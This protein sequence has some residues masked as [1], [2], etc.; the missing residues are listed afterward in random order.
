MIVF[1]GPAGAGKSVQGQFL[2]VRHGWEWLST[3]QILRAST[4]PNVQEQIHSGV[5]VSPETVDRVLV[6]A[7]EGAQAAKEII[8][9]GYPRK[10]QQAE[11][12]IE[13]KDRHHRTIELAIVLEVPLEELQKRLLKRG[14]KDDSTDAIQERLAIYTKEIDSILAFLSQ[15][16]VKI[17]RVNGVGSMGEVHDRIEKELE[18][19]GAIPVDAL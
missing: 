9:D 7:L 6:E 10:Q 11:W 19:S 17:I 3:G 14:R 16:N 1:F 12:I 8:L 2:A 4:D 5:L 15:H 18:V 13:T